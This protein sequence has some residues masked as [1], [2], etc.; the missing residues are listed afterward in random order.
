MLTSIFS[1]GHVRMMNDLLKNAVGVFFLVFFFYYLHELLFG[2]RTRKNF[3]MT[4]LFLILTGASHILDFGVALLFL[5]LYLVLS[6][7]FNVNRKVAVRNLGAI[8]L[9]VGVF[10]VIALV[11]LPSLFTDFFKGLYFLEDLLAASGETA[12]PI[13]F[14]FDPRGGALTVPILAVGL[15]L[16]AYEWKAQNKEAF[17][18]LLAMTIT[19][20]ALSFP[21]IPREWLW[22]FLLMEFIPAGFIL[23]YSFSKI[24]RRIAV[25]VFLLIAVSPVIVQGVDASRRMGPTITNAGYEEL[26][27]IR[28]VV[29]AN[30]AVVVE[31]RI[32]Y[33]VEYVLECSIVRRPSPDLWQ[34]YASVL[35]LF[36]KNKSPIPPGQVLFEGDHFVLIRL[37]RRK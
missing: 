11:G 23:G 19:G 35:G 13:L 15:V 34:S 8:F 6:V 5:G 14:L 33:W 36:P 17:L 21:L 1:A 12:H 37:P 24:E 16:S 25:A 29:P 32:M 10:A 2:E 27:S 20:L 7:V 26:K 22:R 3:F 18:P 31:P 4:S 9:L 30:S 28:T